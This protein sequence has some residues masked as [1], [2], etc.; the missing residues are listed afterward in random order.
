MG[1]PNWGGGSLASFPSAGHRDK[2]RC[3]QVLPQALIP[4]LLFL[5]PCSDLSLMQSSLLS[6]RFN[7][8][9]ADSKLPNAPGGDE[10]P[11]CIGA[12]V[13]WVW[14][15][16][17]RCPGKGQGCWMDEEARGPKG[18]KNWVKGPFQSCPGERDARVLLR[19]SLGPIRAQKLSGLNP[20]HSRLCSLL[21]FWGSLRWFDPPDSVST[22]CIQDARR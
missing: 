3:C 22:D 15:I 19:H 16:P 8:F 21:A 20:S 12:D 9:D 17:S 1:L 14:A 7:R 6:G 11:G 4:W 2:P 5:C 18:P 13:L 10:Q